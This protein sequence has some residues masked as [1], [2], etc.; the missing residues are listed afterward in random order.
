MW[1]DSEW[2]G[3]TGIYRVQM[4]ASN[5]FV[6]IGQYIS[7]RAPATTKRTRIAY[8]RAQMTYDEPEITEQMPNAIFCREWQR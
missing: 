5:P 7:D 4:L 1:T 6:R 8:L 3:R 2:P